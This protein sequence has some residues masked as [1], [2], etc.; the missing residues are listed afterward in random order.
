MHDFAPDVAVADILT[1]G[2]A[3]AAEL[4][5]VPLAT[6]V[7]HVFPFVAARPSDLLDRRAPP[8]HARSARRCGRARTGASSCRRWSRGARV[9]RDPPP[10]RARPAAVGPHRALARADDGRDAAPARVPAALGALGAGR[11]AAAVGAA[12]RAGRAAAGA[13][14][15]RARRPLDLAGPGAR[16]AARRARGPRRRARARDRHLQRPRAG[17]AD[18]GARERRPRPLALLRQDDAAVRRRRAPRRPRHARARA[19]RRLLGRRL[20]GRA[21]T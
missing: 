16:A 4:E 10:P 15:G 19:R 21:A 9:Q 8:A 1:P 20:P 11:R 7:P 3:L 2:P 12:G 18:P 14:A 5:G 6:L 17:G 13:R